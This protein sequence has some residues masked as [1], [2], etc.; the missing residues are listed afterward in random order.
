MPYG[1]RW[2]SQGTALPWP[3][4]G[5]GRGG[6]PRCAWPGWWPRAGRA[7]VAEDEAAWLRSEAEALRQELA[8]VEKR[9]QELEKKE[10]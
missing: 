2:G 7:Y 1:R 9:L 4:V 10:A 5:R 3:Y 8:A 6:L